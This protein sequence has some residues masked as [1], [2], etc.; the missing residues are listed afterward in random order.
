MDFAGRGS[1][2]A[3]RTIAIRAMQLAG[4]EYLVETFA[5]KNHAVLQP[6]AEHRFPSSFSRRSPPNIYFGTSRSIIRGCSATSKIASVVATARNDSG[7]AEKPR[8]VILF[9]HDFS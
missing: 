6:F 3:Q 1:F 8:S 5:H 9:R 2:F 7:L 4:L